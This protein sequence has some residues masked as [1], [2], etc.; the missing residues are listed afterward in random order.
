MIYTEEVALKVAEFLLQIKAVVLRPSEPFTWASGI[1]SPIYCDNRKILSYPNVRNYIRQQINTIAE[2]KYGNIDYVAGVAT[3]GI[4]HGV[5]VAQDLG[6]PFVYV[7]S[8]PKGHGLENLVEGEIAPGKKVLVIEDL[9]STGKSSL[10]AVNAL[11]EVG[12]VV[13]SM[14]SIFDYGFANTQ[15]VFKDAK[16]ELISLSNYDSIIKKAQDINYI[17]ENQIETLKEWRKDPEN[18]C[19]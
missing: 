14:I 11:R 19:K 9:V 12:F 13:N 3:G 1:K 18:W 6:L 17:K 8:V 16:C 5:L 10:Q 4:P 2:E 7:R 15:N